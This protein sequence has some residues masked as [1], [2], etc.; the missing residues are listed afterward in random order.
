MA[1]IKP[2]SCLEE[3]PLPPPHLDY[4][5]VPDLDIQYYDAAF[6]SF[7]SIEKVSKIGRSLASPAAA[8]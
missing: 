1:V 8:N 5:F 4:L 2:Q 7:A 3:A 6:Y